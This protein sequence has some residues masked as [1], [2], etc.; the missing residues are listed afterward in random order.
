VCSFEHNGYGE[1][2][3]ELFPADPDG[4]V[5]TGTRNHD[6]FGKLRAPEA[7]RGVWNRNRLKP[8]ED[9]DKAEG[10]G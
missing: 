3:K 10:Q 6:L 5:A 1:E 4:S 7:A 2:Y 9:L 8:R